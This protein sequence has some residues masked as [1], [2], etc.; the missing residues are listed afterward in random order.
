MNFF[1]SVDQA[2]NLHQLQNRISE[3]F[4][5]LAG[6]LMLFLGISD[7]FLGLSQFIVT[8][9]V[10]LAF[11]FLIG[12]G[13]MRKWGYHP[14]IMHALVLIGYLTI[15]LNYF[16]NEGYKG[17]SMYAFFIFVVVTAILFEGWQK[18]FWLLFGFGTISFL[19]YGE[20]SGQFTVVPH[21]QNLENLFWDHWI[22]L[23]WTGL[24]S[25]LGIH[26]F[27][28]NYHTQNK[29]MNEVQAEKIKALE[30]L[31]EL[32]TKKNQLLAL[33]S[34]DLKNPVG[35][36]STTLELVDRGVFDKEDLETIL[37]D[38][39]GQSFHLSK[40]LNNTLNWVLTEMEEG[41]VTLEKVSVFALTKE[42]GSTMEVQ[43]LRKNQHLMYH[44]SGDDQ[45]LDL[46][47]NE[48]KII[49]K[50]LLDNAIKF[51]PLGANIEIKLFIRPTEI[52]WEV[53]NEGQVIPEEV[54]HELFEFK[55]KSSRG[56]QLE[57]GTGL[58]LPLC[59]K[60]ADKLEMT[61]GFESASS[62][63]NVF[64]LCKK[65]QASDGLNQ[66]HSEAFSSMGSDN[67]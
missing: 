7:Y 18:V 53:K 49:L 17:P 42:I 19:F 37:N 21:Y 9:K 39:K 63:A 14:A 13:M 24:F 59:K 52:R 58:G 43:A 66:D 57:K 10:V 11:P 41:E 33:L 65:R 12:Y 51:S 26:L 2:G 61:L 27:I 30:K 23:L 32:N 47:V 3:I 29:W 22:T 5:F 64:F 40:V 36:L 38:L 25:F 20:I 48:I 44:F 16:H 45:I 62:Q 54:S 46:E 31:E 50:N 34:H 56:T 8:V 60:I 55:V 67:E 15:T 6:F 28:K 1:R 35:T 4:A